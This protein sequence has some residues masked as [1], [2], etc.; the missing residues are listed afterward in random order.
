MG[1]TDTAPAIDGCGIISIDPPSFV[2]VTFYIH[3]NGVASFRT[4]FY[5]PATHLASA[6]IS[7][8]LTGHGELHIVAWAHG[9]FGKFGQH[10][11]LTYQN[12]L[13]CHPDPTTTTTSSTT[14]SSTTS[15][16]VRATT[17]TTVAPR[18]GTAITATT[19]TTTVPKAPTL[20]MT[21][22]DNLGAGAF[23]LAVLV[24]G[25]ALVARWGRR[26]SL[27]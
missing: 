7:D 17:T 13:V 27:T 5:D 8:L 3:V 1:F 21:G 20:P 14:T 24:A 6:D 10:D 12:T 26:R 4:A 19:S 11:S 18:I 15:T 16:T 25:A 2:K 9:D 23:G 22:A